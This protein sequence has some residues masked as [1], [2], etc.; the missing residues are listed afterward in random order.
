M[1]LE[2]IEWYWQCI[3]ER[4]SRALEGFFKAQGYFRATT[5]F[6]AHGLNGLH[7]AS[8]DGNLDVVKLLVHKNKIDIDSVA[9][10]THWTA[11]HFACS[12]SQIEVVRFLLESNASSTICSVDH[13]LA[14]DV[15][16]LTVRAF[17]DDFQQ[18]QSVRGR[19]SSLCQSEKVDIE[20]WKLFL[21]D[22]P[23]F[24][25]NCSCNTSGW[26]PLFFVAYYGQLEVTRLMLEYYNVDVHLRVSQL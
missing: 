4:D 18:S 17:I 11:L 21:Q 15:G 2:I 13:A 14:Y 26:S 10:M 9:K 8:S 16:T 1:D 19:L 12:N 25:L 6:N 23:Y 22:N 5:L 7:V 3:N 24:N 20:D